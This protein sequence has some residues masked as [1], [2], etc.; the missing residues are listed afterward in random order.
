MT[1]AWCRSRSIAAL[2]SNGAWP[3]SLVPLG[4]SAPPYGASERP[5]RPA[6]RFTQPLIVRANILSVGYQK[7]GGLPAPKRSALVG[8]V[9]DDG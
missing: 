5:K 1:C 8:A 7:P 2:T 9:E 6:I 4:T 3:L